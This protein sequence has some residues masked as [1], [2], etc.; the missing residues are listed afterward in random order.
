[1]SASPTDW[2][3]ADG[4]RILK[5]EPNGLLALEKPAGVRAHPN[6]NK[7]DN[8]AL[9]TVPYD[10]EA[11]C[12]VWQDEKSGAQRRLWL[13]HR[14]DAPT[15]GL[16]LCCSNEKLAVL[17]REAF[18]ERKVEKVYHAVV[19][20][21]MPGY[22][23]VWKDRFSVTRKQGLVRAGCGGAVEASVAVRAIKAVARPSPLTLLEL[24]PHTGRTHQLR[25]QCAEHDHP[26][27]GDATYGDFRL[28]RDLAKA[29]GH[30]RLFLHSSSLSF[31]LGK[32]HNVS[33]SAQSLLPE[34]FGELVDLP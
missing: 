6:D 9:L 25:V 30:K 10:A 1:M 12:Y 28:N 14:L 20:G 2:P 22:K 23:T 11:E 13:L 7:P 24:R 5:S 33:F 19:R 31:T 15:S 26:I 29:T 3:L 21:S 16:I 17:V 4:V 32:P 27:V 8:G 34:A 18:A